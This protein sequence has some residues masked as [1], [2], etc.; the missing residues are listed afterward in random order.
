[1]K[2][3]E[4][5]A[6]FLSRFEHGVFSR[7]DFHKHWNGDLINAAVPIKPLRTEGETY[8]LVWNQG[9]L[10]CEWLLVFSEQFGKNDRFQVLVAWDESVRRISRH[11]IK[12]RGEIGSL[13]KASACASLQDAIKEGVSVQEFAGWSKNVFESE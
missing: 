6:G 8:R 5:E 10:I 11:I 1:M 7:T 4:L 3:S 2:T 12:I 13:A 9:I